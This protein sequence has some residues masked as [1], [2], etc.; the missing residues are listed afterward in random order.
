MNPADPGDHSD[1]PRRNDTLA[2]EDIL[3]QTRRSG[4]V[5]EA[6]GPVAPTV[7]R[8]DPQPFR[9]TLRPPMALLNVLDD[10]CDTGEVLRIR[11][12]SFVIGRIEGDL[13]IPHDEG[14]SG[15][16]AEINRCLE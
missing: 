10:G 3:S 11:T 2:V 6:R 14:I 15:R 4:T 16:H 12:A 8:Y 1:G 13:I 9:P 7:G 5:V